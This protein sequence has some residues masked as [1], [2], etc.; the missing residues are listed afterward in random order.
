MANQK[1][2]LNLLEDV[3]QKD[4]L[5]M[6]GSLSQVMWESS[7]HGCMDN[8]TCANLSELMV[9]MVALAEAIG[10]EA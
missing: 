3:T 7:E 4:I 9:N 6:L 5:R 1:A 10:G 8:G 2:V